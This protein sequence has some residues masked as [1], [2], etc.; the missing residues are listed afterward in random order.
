MIVLERIL[1]DQ[2][3]SFYKFSEYA[4]VD[5]A[6]L[7]RYKNGLKPKSNTINVKRI[8]KALNWKGDPLELFEEVPDEASK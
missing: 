1:L 3:I 4:Q 5:Q 7:S 8:V 2:E 6:M